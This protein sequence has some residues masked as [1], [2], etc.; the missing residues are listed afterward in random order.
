MK[1]LKHLARYCLLSLSA[2]AASG[3]TDNDQS[4]VISNETALERRGFLGVQV[5]AAPQN[6]AG[7]P[8]QGVSVVNVF[9]NSTA[10]LS[11]IINGDL[12]VAINDLEIRMPQ[13]LTNIL[14]AAKAGANVKLEIIRNQ[15]SR[16]IDTVLAPL[17]K[18]QFDDAN[19][20]H[21]EVYTDAG[22][23]R[24][25]LTLPK[26]KPAPPVVFILQG[27]DCSSIEKP[28][29]PQDAY[30]RL[31][32]MLHKNGFATFRLEK[33][34]VGDSSGQDCREIR[35]D[36]ET[37]GFIDGLKFLAASTS[38]NR[39][40]IYVLGISL[41]GIWAPILA[42][43]VPLKGIISFGTIGKTW[44]EY[45]YENSR[46]QLLLAGKD[47][48]Q[49]END[50]KLSSIFWN[51]L[52]T[53]GENP[54]EIMDARPELKTIAQSLTIDPVTDEYMHLFGRHYSFVKEI[55][56]VNIAE[57]WEHVE[58]RTLLLWGI[59]DYIASESDQILIE[60]IL[61]SND[62]DVT[63]K[64]VESDHYWRQSKS[65]AESYRNLRENKAPAFQED[66]LNQI[67]QWLL[68]GIPGTSAT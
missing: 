16:I 50:L 35:F 1:I 42:N 58:S 38:I 56:E 48:S 64:Y 23:L 28:L 25:I 68:A 67:E 30:V 52:F 53:S 5:S 11:G 32:K 49:I 43:E 39:D 26:N 6:S 8:V 62:K 31:I 61:L 27:F 66:I 19:V 36:L 44:E 13:D 59:G 18:E 9:D 7:N 17:P 37:K 47:Y 40:D 29:T 10:S 41:G 2:C 21:D 60:Q 45:M 12:L 51:E 57:E 15:E 4:S 65:F 24:S 63:L 55:N 22:I 54:R 46:R 3:Q 14:G 33:S 20:I 34:N